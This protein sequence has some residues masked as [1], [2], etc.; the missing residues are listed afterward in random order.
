ME[1]VAFPGNPPCLLVGLSYMRD[2]GQSAY[3]ATELIQSSLF[4]TLSSEIETESG[5]RPFFTD[6]HAD[7]NISHSKNL[8]AVAYFASNLSGNLPTAA[9]S[10]DHPQRTGCDVQYIDLRKAKDGVARRAFSASERNYI[11]SAHDDNE[12]MLRFYRIWTFKE[13]YIKLRGWSV[14]DM[15]KT[16]DFTPDKLAMDTAA[17]SPQTILDLR[18]YLIAAEP[19]ERYVLSVVWEDAGREGETR[20]EENLLTD[21]PDFRWFSEPLP[22][23]PF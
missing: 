16:P 11:A 17:T 22:I 18:Q 8:I 21:C 4:D 20:R 5:G 14:F 15:R 13:S 6:R 23:V 19:L 10:A 12:R 7:F 3:D 1:Q 2:N 9:Y